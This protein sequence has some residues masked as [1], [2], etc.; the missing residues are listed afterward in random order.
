M[1]FDTKK[2]LL[3]IAGVALLFVLLAGSIVWFVFQ[4]TAAPVRMAREHLEA[5]N[6]NDYPRAYS[7]LS[8]SLQAELSLDNFT[9]LVR[10]EERRVGKECRL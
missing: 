1:A 2:I 8:R 4:M 3:I 5:L 9:N 10:S 7:H 6:Q